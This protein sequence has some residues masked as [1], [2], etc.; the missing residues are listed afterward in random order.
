MSTAPLEDLN[1]EHLQWTA[2][3]VAEVDRDLRA[4]GGQIFLLAARHRPSGAYVG[5][6]FINH[7]SFQ[8]QF[9]FQD[10]T[11]VDPRH[12]NKGLGR[13]LKAANLLRVIAAC[14]AAE[15]VRTGNAGSNAPMLSINHALGFREA[16]INNVFQVPVDAARDYLR[17][18]ATR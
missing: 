10:D 16:Y 13:W 8:P 5:Y 15:V 3:R 4:R 9:L 7:F 18:R 17:E 14:P 6:T 2:E 11:A 1:V 12:R